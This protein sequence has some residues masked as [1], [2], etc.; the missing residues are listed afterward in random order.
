MPKPKDSLTAVELAEVFEQGYGNIYQNRYVTV[1]GALDEVVSRREE[2]GLGTSV[3]QEDELDDFYLV[4]LP[5]R[6]AKKRIRIRCQIKDRD[7]VFFMDG[8]GD[9]YY[10][11]FVTQWH[12]IDKDKGQGPRGKVPEK[13]KSVTFDKERSLDP[14]S[15]SA[16][17]RKGGEVRF[18]SGR[19]ESGKVELEAVTLYDC[20]K[21]EIRDQGG[22]WRTVW[23]ASQK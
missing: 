21:F 8:R 23:Q 15:D 22:D 1:S 10:K 17:F 19:I 5:E 6:G 7:R 14:L 16:L 18:T 20:L 2:L 3:N 9:L 13:V 12:D 4:G 11:L